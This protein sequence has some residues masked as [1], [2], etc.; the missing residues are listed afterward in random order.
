MEGSIV[1]TFGL[2]DDIKVLS[3]I[4]GMSKVSES[5]AI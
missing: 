4:K 5:G 1:P 2:L 3:G